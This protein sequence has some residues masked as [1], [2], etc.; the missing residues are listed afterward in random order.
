MLS[1]VRDYTRKEVPLLKTQ[2]KGKFIYINTF[3]MIL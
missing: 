2:G 1:S 3:D